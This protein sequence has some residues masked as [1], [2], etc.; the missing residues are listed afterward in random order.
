MQNE[1]LSQTQ[2]ALKRSMLEKY[3]DFYDFAPVG[4]PNPR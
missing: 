2:V 4:F 3:R 1:T